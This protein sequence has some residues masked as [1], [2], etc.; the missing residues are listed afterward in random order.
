MLLYGQLKA[1]EA[2]DNNKRFTY[3]K[4]LLKPLWKFCYNFFFRLGFLDGINGLTICYLGALEDVE[5]YRALR[6]AEQQYRLQQANYNGVG[7]KVYKVEP[8]AN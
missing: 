4:L 3:A 5:R 1:R 6:T 8:F 7:K 2:F